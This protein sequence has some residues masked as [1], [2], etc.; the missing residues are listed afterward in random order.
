MSI[1]LYLVNQFWQI[2]LQAR[3]ADLM[4]VERPTQS[5]IISF[6]TCGIFLLLIFIVIPRRIQSSASTDGYSLFPF[7]DQAFSVSPKD[8]N[9]TPLCASDF[10]TARNSIVLILP[11]AG[12]IVLRVELFR[13]VL[14]NRQCSLSGIEVRLTHFAIFSTRLCAERGSCYFLLQFMII[15]ISRIDILLQ[16]RIYI[17]LGTSQLLMERQDMYYQQLC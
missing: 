10:F 11:A 2:P 12:A 17:I 3:R 4:M 16:W 5:S 14:R 8:Q 13:L 1:R 15:C 7:R 9:P 6:F